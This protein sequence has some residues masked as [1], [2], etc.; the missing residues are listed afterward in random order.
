MVATTWILGGAG[1]L[2]AAMPAR[3]IMD[4][5][6]DVYTELVK[7]HWIKWLRH[8]KRITDPKAAYTTLK[9]IMIKDMDDVVKIQVKEVE[10]M[11]KK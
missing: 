2:I 3:F 8:F 11:M 10:G 6:G 4:M 7:E 9:K 1:L 5:A